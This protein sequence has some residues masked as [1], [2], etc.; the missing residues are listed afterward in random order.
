LIDVYINCCTAHVKRVSFWIYS[1]QVSTLNK[2]YRSC[3]LAINSTLLVSRI[4]W[5]R[6][7]RDVRLLPTVQVLPAGGP[8]Q[9]FFSVQIFPLH[10]VR[11]GSR[12]CNCSA[13]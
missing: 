13:H 6:L 11:A 2:G 5:S 9:N 1:C 8:P 10:F 3:S 7:G 4:L 12:L